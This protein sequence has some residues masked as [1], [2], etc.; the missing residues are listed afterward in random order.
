MTI[1]L[2]SRGCDGSEL[3]E[4]S[5]SRR[6]YGRGD[7]P[8]NADVRII[9]VNAKFRLGNTAMRHLVEDFRAIGERLEAVGEARWDDQCQPVE[10]ADLDRVPAA[11]LRR[12]GPD[13]HDD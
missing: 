2:T 11:E 12:V 4:R 5:I 6:H 8:G 13:I 9:P 3:R 7:R 1:D 10:G